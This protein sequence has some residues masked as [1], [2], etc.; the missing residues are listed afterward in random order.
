MGPT[1][2]T[3]NA[4]SGGI[5]LYGTGSIGAV[6]TGSAYGVYGTTSS[7]SGTNIGV[8]G[9]VAGSGEGVYGVSQ[10]GAG[11]YGA[12]DHWRSRQRR[13]RRHGC[14]GETA[15]AARRS[16]DTA[17]EPATALYGS[18]SSGY[19]LIA[20]SAGHDAIYGNN[21][22][23][24]G[25]DISGT[26]IGIIGRAPSS[27][28]PLVLTD[29]SGNDVFFV[30]GA[31]N[32]HYHGS[33]Q[34]FARTANGATVSSFSAENDDADRRRHGDG[35]THRRHGDDSARSVIRGI[36]RSARAVP[37]FPD[38]RRRYARLV[39]RDEGRRRVYRT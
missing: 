2:I 11:V 27:G 5:G 25:G 23:G 19:G 32:V 15:R 18:A 39:R 30:D 35:A 9:T 16:R 12:G 20:Q 1:A 13:R 14:D 4:S 36:D 3:A 6:G 34:N 8:F 29:S 21:T 22:N 7:T 37:G 26:Y 33:F 10:S 28:Y 38:A 24:N 31:G 17:A